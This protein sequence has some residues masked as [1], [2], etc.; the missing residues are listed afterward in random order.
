MGGSG[1]GRGR[2]PGRGTCGRPGWLGGR[3]AGYRLPAHGP[4][5]Q[6]MGQLREMIGVLAVFGQ[7]RT[8]WPTRITP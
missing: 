1:T 3:G 8:A 2:L 5:G 6:A 4:V 7:G